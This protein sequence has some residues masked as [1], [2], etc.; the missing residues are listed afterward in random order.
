MENKTFDEAWEAWKKAREA[1]KATPEYKAKETAWEVYKKA[2]EA[3]EAT[4]ERKAKDEAWE[5]YEKALVREA[6]MGKVKG[7][8]VRPV[9][10]FREKRGPLEKAWKSLFL[11]KESQNNMFLFE[12]AAGNVRW[13]QDSARMG[14]I[15]P[16][17]WQALDKAWEGTK[18]RFRNYGKF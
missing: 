18:A 15:S 3:L 16:N 11:L 14:L 2:E 10:K 4:P 9:E 6:S 1:W 8:E 7:V 13:A 5:V 12:E 17:E